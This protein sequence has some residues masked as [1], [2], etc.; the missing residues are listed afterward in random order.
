LWSSGNELS[1]S[2]F[3]KSQVGAELPMDSEEADKEN[4]ESD[5]KTLLYVFE[6]G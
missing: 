6:R 2:T 5:G 4:S 3:L 1:F